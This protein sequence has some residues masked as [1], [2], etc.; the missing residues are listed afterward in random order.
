MTSPKFI[1]LCGSSRFMKVFNTVAAALSNQGSVVLTPLFISKRQLT[2]VVA[3]RLAQLHRHKIDIADEVLIIDVDGYIGNRTRREIVYAQAHHKRIR[4]YSQIP[5]QAGAPLNAAIVI[6]LRN[7]LTQSPLTLTDSQ[8]TYLL[9]HLGDLNPQIRDDLGATL[10]SR[11]FAEQVLTPAQR[12]K[13]VQFLLQRRSLFQD[14]DFPG[15]NAVFTRTFTA[16]LTAEVLDSDREH[17]WLAPIAQQRFIEDALTY[18]DR[19]QDTRGYVPHKGWAHG[20]AHG[21]DLLGAAWQHPQFS[22]QQSVQALQ[23]LRHVIRRQTRPFQFDEEPRLA[24]PLILALASHHLSDS[25]LT[26]WLQGTDEILWQ[27]FSFDDLAADA[28]LHN[29]LSL[30]HHL[31]FW[32]PVTDPNRG[33]IETLSRSYYRQYGYY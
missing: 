10:L 29:W 30:L 19:E 26:T 28:R 13:I 15:T 12:H 8:V 31:Y 3:Q 14:I 9:D 24:H 5:A 4:F 18:L 17:P 33:V 23:L 2:P 6:Q 32:L 20:I 7:K 27:H 1:A 22:P 11:G 16:L 25:T 21:S